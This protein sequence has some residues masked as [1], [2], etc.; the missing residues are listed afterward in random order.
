[1]VQKQVFSFQEGNARM[2]PLLGGK[3]ANLAEMTRAGLPVPPGFTVTTEACLAYFKHGNCLSGQLLDQIS[4]ALKQLE[5]EKGQTFG[6]PGRPLL[7]SVR[8]G[9]VTSMPGMMDT[10]LNLGLNDETVEGLAEHTRNP[11]F[12]FDCYR[13][14]IQMFGNVVLGIDSYH[15]EQSLLR[16]KA[17]EKLEYDQEVTAEGWRRLISDYKQMIKIKAG[18]DFP[19]DV[20]LQLHMAIEAVFKSWNNQRAQ[21]YRKIHRI[22]DDQG[23][24]VNVQSMVF[25]NMGMDSGTGVVFT[26][27]PSTGENVLYGEYLINAQGEDVVAGTRTPMPIQAMKR[28]APAI[29]E[30]L[31]QV[32]KQLERHYKDMQ[33]IEFTVETGK[34]YLLQTRNGKRNA[35][36][37]IR[38]AVAMVKEG[39]LS[40]EQALLHIETSHLD[41]LLHRAIDENAI[42]HVIATGLP[43]SPGAATGQIVFDTV[44]AVEWSKAGTPVVLVRPETTPEDIQGMLASEG[45]LTSRGGMTS[46]AAVVARG[47]GKPCVCGCDEIRIDVDAKTLFADEKTLTEGDWLTLDGGSGRVIPGKVPLMQAE[48]SQ[49]LLQ[50]LKW[51]DELRTLRIFTNADNPEDAETARNFGAEGIGLCRTE[52]MF[53]SPDRLP[54]VQRMILADS[55]EERLAALKQL[56]PMQQSDFEG[57]FRVMDGCPVTIRLLDPPLHEFLPNS[58]EIQQKLDS[59]AADPGKVKE[60]NE[61]QR[62]LTKIAELHETNPMLGQR[63]CRLGILFPEIYRMQ[64]EA[65]F[66]AADRCLNDGINVLP[67]IMIPL[68]GHVSELKLM[69]ELV[70]ETA[71]KILGTSNLQQCRYKV[72]TMI[73]VP[74]AALTAKQIASVADFFS[75]GTNDLTQMT[76]GYSRDDAEGKFLTQYIDRKILPVNPFQVLDVEGVG[77]LIEM[78]VSSGRMVEPSLKTGICGEHGGDKDS[79]L[80][81]HQIGLD[82]VS[83]SPYRIPLARIAAAQAVILEGAPNKAEERAV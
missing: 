11:R 29:Y 43:A 32:A 46:H 34:L 61:L 44:T 71:E 13:R 75:F 48:M 2:K 16:L 3:G 55:R 5:A 82:Y 26:R 58:V 27:N 33:D 49:E 70:D 41:Q 67:E 52:H 22:P 66:R 69:R 64:V 40:K 56:L 83:C 68:V 9:S 81:C 65:I 19:Q 8:S 72:G 14:L 25:G 10:I 73:E 35:Q 63:G 74:R 36:A 39:I 18:I 45:V 15:F 77:Q 80:F 20:L 21:I 38:I 78:A 37:A 50:M 76:F 17:E 60:K 4:D 31:S 1:M 62:V 12:A 7:V 28:E 53:F 42:K 57:M 23:T 51:A 6:D 24:A 47:M 79:I 59:I 54:V 30:Q